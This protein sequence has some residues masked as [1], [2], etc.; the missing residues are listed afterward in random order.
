MATFP[1]KVNYATGD[2]L[3]A[4]NMNDIGGAINLLDGAQYSA[5]KNKIINGDFNINQRAF[6]STTTTGGYGFDRFLLNAADGTT[7]YSAQTFTTGAAPVAGYEAKNYARLVTT[8]QTA[9][10][11]VSRLNQYL[12]NVRT[13]AG[14]TVTVSFWAQAGSGTPGVA[15]EFQQNFGSGG[16]PSAIVNTIIASP[17]KQT[18]STSWARY[19]FTIAVPSLSG[20]TIGTTDPGY[21]S[22]GIWVS[23]GTDFNARTGSLGIQSNTFNFWGVQVEEADTASPFQTAT[24]TFQGELA[25]CQRYY[26]QW[27]STAALYNP[28][29][30][31]FAETTTVIKGLRLHPVQMRSAPTLTI[32]GPFQDFGGNGVTVSGSGTTTTQ[33]TIDGTAASAVFTIWQGRGVRSDNSLNAKVAVSS[34]L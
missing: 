14:Q 6:T 34:E 19:S 31:G 29:I 10:T 20:K 7:T 1:S 12:E 32:T 22:L 15:V 9:T 5:G 25:V 26:Y 3:T 23:A 28:F 16:S 8:G 4:T 2:V 33:M 21:L 27:D 30:T 17:A 11:A 24:G 13:F 18:I